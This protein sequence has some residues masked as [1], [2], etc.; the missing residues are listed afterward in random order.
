MQRDVFRLKFLFCLQNL[1]LSVFYHRILHFYLTCVSIYAVTYKTL[2]ENN[3]FNLE[4]LS[5]TI[6]QW[7][8]KKRKFKTE[9]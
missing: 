4:I 8:F 7:I 2:Y 6:F 5:N 9:Y 3:K 1:F